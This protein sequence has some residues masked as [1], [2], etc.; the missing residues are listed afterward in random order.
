MH[1]NRDWSKTYYPGEC[2]YKRGDGGK[3][4]VKEE[5]IREV[6]G[7]GGEEEEEG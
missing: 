6:E 3:E 2:S 1:S 5:R 7:E 4:G